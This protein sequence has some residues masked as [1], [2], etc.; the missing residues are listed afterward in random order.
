[1]FNRAADQPPPA[2]EVDDLE[3][4]AGM[5]EEGG[6]YRLPVLPLDGEAA[7]STPQMHV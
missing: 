1:M 5:L 4:S 7:P 3:G 6:V 2:A